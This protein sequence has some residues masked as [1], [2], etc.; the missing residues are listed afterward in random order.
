MYISVAIVVVPHRFHAALAWFI[1]GLARL[2]CVEHQTH[3]ICM[4]H[5]YPFPFLGFVAEMRTRTKKT[6]QSIAYCPLNEND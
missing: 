4:L 2:A 1:R 3:Q 5:L 6:P